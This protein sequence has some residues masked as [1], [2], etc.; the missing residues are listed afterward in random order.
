MPRAVIWVDGPD[1]PTFLQG[2]LSN[3]VEGLPVGG[4]CAAL[5]LDSTGHLRAEMTVVRGGPQAFTI[6]TDQAQGARIAEL[7]EEYHFSEDVEIIGPESVSSVT[8]AQ[9][10]PPGVGDL[11]LTGR[12]PGTI[13][14][15]SA[16]GDALG[17]VLGAD[18]IDPQ[19][20]EIRRVEAGVP[21]FGQDITS[22]HLVH[23]A[24]LQDVAVSFDKGCYLGQETVARVQYRGGVNRRLVGVRLAAPVPAGSVVRV[25]TREVGTLTSVVPSPTFGPI[26][27]GVLRKEAEIGATVAVGDT[28]GVV[29]TLPF[30]AAA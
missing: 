7:L 30:H 10:P 6:V 29:T 26:A 11:S 4:Q 20:T 22:A 9:S 23:E 3:D 17:A 18:Q 5:L 25:G 1:A 21:H 24:G 14:V 27:L 12:V 28:T 16:D 15:I 8:V 19:L 13:E 2:L